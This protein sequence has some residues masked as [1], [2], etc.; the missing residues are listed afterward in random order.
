MTHDE[1]K[2]LKELCE[3]ATPGP[4]KGD[5]FEMLAPKAPTLIP[6]NVKI[7]WAEDHPMNE[8]DADF[9]AAAREALPKLIEEVERLKE[10][11][12]DLEES[13][14]EASDVFKRNMG[15][16]NLKK[17]AEVEKERDRA[18]RRVEKLEKVLTSL[19][20]D[21]FLTLDWKHIIDRALAEDDK[22]KKTPVAIYRINKE[23]GK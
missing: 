13:Y 11:N 5:E 3:N 6:G 19:N 21:E 22:T 18:L 23:A 14:H 8:W 4:W 16:Q 2:K 10:E 1:L 12:K 15:E 9:I 7:V 17:R 20:E